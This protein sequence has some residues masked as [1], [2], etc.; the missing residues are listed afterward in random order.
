MSALTTKFPSTF[1]QYI[2]TSSPVAKPSRSMPAGTRQVTGSSRSSTSSVTSLESKARDRAEDAEVVAARG[3]V[4]LLQREELEVAV[5]VLARH[6]DA[7]TDGE[8]LEVDL[9]ADGTT[10]GLRPTLDLDAD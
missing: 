9:V 5:A 8:A 10:H 3:R 2:F 1:W 4:L 7:L 6:V